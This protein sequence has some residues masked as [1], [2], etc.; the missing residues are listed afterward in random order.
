MEAVDGMDKA[1]TVK[2]EK[3]DEDRVC[4]NIGESKWA[5]KVGIMALSM[6]ILWPLTI[7][8]GIGMYIQGKL[9]GE[10]KKEVANYFVS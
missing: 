2:L 8:S 3:I 9:P 1:I 5:D 10:I 4:V 6:I 7:T